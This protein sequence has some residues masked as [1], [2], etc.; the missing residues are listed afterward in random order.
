MMTYESTTS[1]KKDPNLNLGRKVDKETDHLIK[2]RNNSK[3]YI[4]KDLSLNSEA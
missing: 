4:S 3:K 1:A 2:G